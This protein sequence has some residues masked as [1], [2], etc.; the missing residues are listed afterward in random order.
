MA[1]NL[2]PVGGVAAQFF[3]NTGAVLTGGKLY[4]YL[5]GTTTPTPTYTTS[6]GNVARTNPII[7]DAA[8][9]VPGSGEIW[10]TVGITY[11]FLLTDS[12]DVLIGTYDNISGSVNASQVVYTPA[13]A[14]AVTTNVQDKLRQ[15][16]SVLDFGA[17]GNGVANDSTA[18]SNAIATGKAVYFP[19]GTYLCNVNINSKTILFGDGSTISIIKPYVY[20]SP[21][22]VYTYAAQQTPITGYWNYHSEVRNL[23]FQGTGSGAAATGIGFSFGSGSPA[24]YTAGAEYANNVTFYNCF[25][26]KL[27]KGVQFPFGN[28]GS[29]FYSCGFQSNYYGVYMLDNK[30]GSGDAMHAGN[31]YFYNGEFDYNVC[32]V[33]VNNNTDGFGG[34][35]FT[36][37]IIEYNS[38]GFYL[39]NTQIT[40]FIP[41]QFKDCWYEGNGTASGASTAT[42]DVWTG[43]VKTT[44]TIPVASYILFNGQ[45][46]IDGGFATGIFLQSN[47]SRVYVKNS[48]VE[49]NSGFGGQANSITYGDSNIFFEN[50][51]SASGY[52]TGSG[53]SGNGQCVGFNTSL[54]PNAGSSGFTQQ[55]RF[56]YLPVSYAV[57]TGS[58]LEGIAEKFTTAQA[59]TGA[60]SGTGT[61]VAGNSPKYVNNNQF[62]FTYANTSQYYTPSNTGVTVNAGKWAAFTCDVFLVSA[63]NNVSVSFSDLGSNV[64]GIIYLGVDSV[65]RT[66][67]GVAYFP[68][69]ASVSLYFGT[70][71]AQ[72][73]VINVSAFQC[74]YFA[75][76]GEAENFIAS[77]TYVE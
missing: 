20:T 31:K 51:T 74:K 40:T 42:I 64:A 71:G 49:T 4:T 63:T 66:I 58:G 57:R 10:L 28:I 37:T 6:A 69:T 46:I 18:I 54:D 61:V 52:V 43:N 29:Q 53:Y 19:A 65:W 73:A 32:A 38:I 67:G 41:I 15:Y 75:T 12:N 72:T 30:S 48:R 11:K 9:R 2:S 3:T 76:Q 44:A 23:G 62:T 45:T 47:N 14:G 5:A 26:S 55:S 22:M 17:V 21:A 24:T 25:F 1:V 7:L 68:N 56:R 33:Y 13:G 34:I 77:R 35:S 60:S 50:C 16:V 59:Y 39:Q 8:G 70:L 27:E 36:D